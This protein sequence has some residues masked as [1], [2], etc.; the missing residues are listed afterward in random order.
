MAEL[1]R[2]TL[3]EASYRITSEVFKKIPRAKNIGYIRGY[4]KANDIAHD[5]LRKMIEEAK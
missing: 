3:I 5:V 1:D 4:A 2:A